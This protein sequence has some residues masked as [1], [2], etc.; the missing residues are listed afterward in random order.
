MV[1]Q[2]GVVMKHLRN[3]ALLENISLSASYYGILLPYVLHPYEHFFWK[4]KVK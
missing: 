4:K 1:A 2:F 3:G